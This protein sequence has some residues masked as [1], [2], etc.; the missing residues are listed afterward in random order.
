TP[1]ER[2]VLH[3]IGQGYTNQEMASLLS[4]SVN[5]IQ[6]H[7]SRIMDKL[8]LHSRAELMKYAVRMGLSRDPTA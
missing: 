8:N 3:L 5:T 4:L 6:T 2:E 1:R 7:R